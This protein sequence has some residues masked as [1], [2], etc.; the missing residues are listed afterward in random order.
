MIVIHATIPIFTTALRINFRQ[1]K[2]MDGGLDGVLGYGLAGM[3][4]LKAGSNVQVRSFDGLT[5]S[6]NRAQEE[7]QK[8]QRIV[9]ELGGNGFAS[10]LPSFLPYGSSRGCLS[11][12]QT[13]ACFKAFHIWMTIEIGAPPRPLSK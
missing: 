6:S 5:W 2:G 9:K 8:G 4:G 12:H 13:S 10:F 7:C 11:I 1:W 3:E